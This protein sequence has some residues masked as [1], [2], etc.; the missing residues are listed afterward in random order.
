MQKIT[1]R[2]EALT[3]PCKASH[4]APTRRIEPDQGLAK[5]LHAGQ[6]LQSYLHLHGLEVKQ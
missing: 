3:R 4:D 2:C 1:I 5:P 6:R